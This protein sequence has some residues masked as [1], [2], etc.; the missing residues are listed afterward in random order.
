MLGIS[1]K[2]F[3][4][5][6]SKSFTNSTKI[7]SY[8]LRESDITTLVEQGIIEIIAFYSRCFE[9]TFSNFDKSL[10]KLLEGGKKVQTI[11]SSST[12]KAFV[13]SNDPLSS[14]NEPIYEINIKMSGGTG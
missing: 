12:W 9:W 7:T 3:D 10:V 6:K 2:T 14:K 8:W 5:N 4:K 13:S 1:N 11:H